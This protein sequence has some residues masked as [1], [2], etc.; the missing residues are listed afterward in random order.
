MEHKGRIQ[1]ELIGLLE[2]MRQS[3]E[4]GEERQLEFRGQTT[5]KRRAAERERERK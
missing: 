5:T 2:L 4:Y 1:T 3:R